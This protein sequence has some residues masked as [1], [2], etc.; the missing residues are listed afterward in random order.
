MR[1]GEW[2]EGAGPALSEGGTVLKGEATAG[3]SWAHPGHLTRI[4]IP[5]LQAGRDEDIKSLGV[6]Q[7]GASRHRWLQTPLFP[8]QLQHTTQTQSDLHNSSSEAGRYYNKRIMIA[9]I[10]TSRE[11][12]AK[13]N[14]PI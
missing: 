14:Q 11:T 5:W 13:M 6:A 7:L 4:T 8:T 2:A 10:F 12:M 9:F 1:G 3:H